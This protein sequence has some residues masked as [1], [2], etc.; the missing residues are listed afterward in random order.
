M[1]LDPWA[2]E[3]CCVSRHVNSINLFIRLYQSLWVTMCIV[4]ESYFERIQFFFFS[5]WAADICSGGP[6]IFSKW[7][8][9]QMCCHPEFA[10]PFLKHRQNRFSNIL[11]GPGIF[12]MQMS[13][14]F[15][16]KWPAALATNKSQPVCPL[17]FKSQ[18]LTSPL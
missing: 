8:C 17:K 3:W 9:T 7:C 6:K 14:G 18:A 13:I 16:F 4:H 10:I 1:L 2:A 15:N 12:G 5:F 11:K